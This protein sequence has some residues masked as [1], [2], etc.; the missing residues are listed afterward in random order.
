MAQRSF[1][2]LIAAFLSFSFLL[3]FAQSKPIAIYKSEKVFFARF[4]NKS[5]SS[6]RFRTVAHGKGMYVFIFNQNSVSVRRK[7]TNKLKILKTELYQ[8]EVKYHLQDNQH[9]NFELNLYIDEEMKK[10]NAANIGLIAYDKAG[11]PISTSQIVC[12]KI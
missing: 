4:F 8:N 9:N 6:Q 10:H 3:S 1:S 7:I 12:K 11:L 2:L 5:Q